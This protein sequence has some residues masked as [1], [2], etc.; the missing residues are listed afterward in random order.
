MMLWTFNICKSEELDPKTGQRFQYDD[1]DVAFSGELT[2]VP[3]KFPAVFEPRSPQ[4]AEVARRE[5]SE[6]EKDLNALLP[7][8]KEG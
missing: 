8:H 2:S 5:W 4:H 1:S 6:C 3:F 7:Q